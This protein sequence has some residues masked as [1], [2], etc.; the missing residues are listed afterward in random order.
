VKTSTIGVGADFDERLLQSLADHGDG[1]VYFVQSAIQIP[2]YLTSELGEALETVARDVSIGVRAEGVEVDTL[3]RFPITREGQDTSVLRPGD[4]VS[5]QDVSLVFRLVFPQAREGSTMRAI[6][7]VQDAGSVLQFADT[8]VV[9]TYRDHAA[10][11]AQPRNVVVDRAVAQLYAAKAQAEALELNR[12][13]RFD[14][15]E[16]LLQAVRRRVAQYA[17]SDPELQGVVASLAERQDKYSVKLGAVDMKAEHFANA[18]LSR[19]RDP[20]GKA[21]RQGS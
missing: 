1:H 2:D 10:N 17:G 16:R 15:A 6:F 7:S 14:R 3:N 20:Q 4:L 19:N 9:W 12:A 11:D 8:D 18:S 13:G 21:R 5:R